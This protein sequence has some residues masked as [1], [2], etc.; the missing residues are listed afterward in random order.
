MTRAT[1]MAILINKFI[2]TVNHGFQNKKCSEKERLG[3]DRW[4]VLVCTVI[5]TI[6]A[7][8]ASIDWR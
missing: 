2:I 8:A 6:F 1:D 5:K 7:V 3:W 4:V